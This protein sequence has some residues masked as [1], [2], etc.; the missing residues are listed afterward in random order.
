M[1]N[2]RPRSLYRV[3]S[4]SSSDRSKKTYS[5]LAAI[6]FK[7]VSLG[8]HTMIPSFYPRFKSTIEAI[9]FNVVEH[10][11]PPLSSSFTEA[12]ITITVQEL[13]STTSYFYAPQ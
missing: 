8:T 4:G 13:S 3:L 2:W 6:S 12:V 1:P 7:T 5:V 9:F 10:C 11:L